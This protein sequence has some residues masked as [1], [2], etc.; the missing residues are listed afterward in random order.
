MVTKLFVEGG[1]EN[2]SLLRE[3]RAAFSRMM[4]S[5]G[6]ENRPRVVACGARWNAF[7]RFRHSIQEGAAGRSI[8]L[9]DSEGPVDS[10]ERTNP[11]DHVRAREGDGWEKPAGATDEDLH[12]MVQCMETWFLADKG[13]LREFYGQGFNE[14]K[15]PRKSDIESVPKAEVYSALS[16]STEKAKTKGEYG[17]GAHSF[18]ILAKL[19]PDE[20]EKV[21]P[22]A[23]RFFEH[24]RTL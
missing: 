9:V 22:W 6:I 10:P 21:C 24:L 18:K 7:D 3:C 2:D 15:L 5:A 4:K 23:Q 1:G 14:A 16:R 13:A 8:L 17:K 19:K 20:I 11:W 12:F